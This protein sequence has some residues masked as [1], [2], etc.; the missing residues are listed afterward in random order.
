MSQ[1]F[2]ITEPT[3]LDTQKRDRAVARAKLTTPPLNKNQLRGV[4]AD[5]KKDLLERRGV[6][7]QRA[8]ADGSAEA[9]LARSLFGRVARVQ[10]QFDNDGLEELE[11]HD[12]RIDAVEGF[13]KLVGLVFTRRGVEQVRRMYATRAVNILPWPVYYN[14]H[15]CALRLGGF[16]KDFQNVATVSGYRG[17]SC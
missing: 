9:V 6:P 10:L 14:L 11:S 3:A 17:K 16:I 4:H 15:G 13:P 12:V 7:E 2:D 1:F 5:Y 8:N